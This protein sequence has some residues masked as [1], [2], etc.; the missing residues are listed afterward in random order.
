MKRAARLVFR[1]PAYAALLV[2]GLEFICFLVITVM[3]LAIYGGVR[4][5]SR[6]VYDG[7]TLYTAASGLRATA[8]PEPAPE[9]SRNRRIW[10]FGGSTTRNGEAPDERTVPSIVSRLLNEQ[11]PW[12][13]Q[14]VNF[15]VNS[16][17]S[18]QEVQQLQKALLERED[19][20]DCIVFLD[21][22]NDASYFSLYRSVDAH[23]GYD[24]IKGFI[25]SY[26]SS[27]LGVL[28]PVMAAVHASFTRELWQRLTYAF[29]PLEPDSPLPGELARAMRA[30]YDY[31]NGVAH[32]LNAGFVAFLQPVFWVEP[33]AGNLPERELAERAERFPGVRT[34]FVLVYDAVEPV[35]AGR[36]YFVNLRGTFV[37]RDFPAYQPDGIHQT[38][39]G[40]EALARAML[41]GIRRALEAA[42]PR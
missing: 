16:F 15:G 42:G 1:L 23:E 32:C 20:P 34:N 21:G 37:G 18:L 7:M 17:N 25:E 2:L 30:R 5:G 3:N 10:F 26:W 8:N 11:G 19:R 27:P 9:A 22:A 35:L 4:E 31:A 24:R 6:I 39:Q 41:P 36:P 12:R 28:K 38:D 13:V 14:C 33:P 29:A 40:R